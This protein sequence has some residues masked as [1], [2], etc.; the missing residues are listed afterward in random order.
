MPRKN[1]KH[2]KNHR[3]KH[4]KNQKTRDMNVRP[5]RLVAL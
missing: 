3:D 2:S 1:Y 4:P 5:D